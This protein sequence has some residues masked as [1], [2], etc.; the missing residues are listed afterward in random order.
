MKLAVQP[1]VPEVP[2]LRQRLADYFELTKPRIAAMALITVGAGYLAAAGTGARLVPLIHVLIGSGLVAAGAS[3]WNMWVERYSDGKMRR[4]SNRPLPSGRLN[5]LEVV[6][7]GTFLAV[8]GTNYLLH[9]L[10]SNGPMAAL[11]AG[12]SFITYVIVYT[13]LKQVTTWNTHIGAIPG[14]LPPVIGWA[15][16]TGS[17]DAGAIGLFLVLLFW[18]LPH[19]MAIAWMYRN[20]YGQ[21][22]LKM[23][24]VLDTTGAKTSRSM[25]F[26]CVI[27]MASSLFPVLIT[28]FGVASIAYLV[29]ALM[30]G[31]YFLRSTFRFNANRTEQ[32][33]R[34]VLKASIL[35]LPAMMGLLLAHAILVTW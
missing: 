22:G 35:Y 9:S 23:I 16:A 12:L 27:L 30:L 2:A 18:Q 29:L 34:Q 28:P 10:G 1:A 4:T 8:T 19:F 6:A 7:I 3:A 24:P 32:Q 33:A 20:D 25:I 13:P 5:H 15:A 26:W 31:W 21:A 17:I 11:V 14:A